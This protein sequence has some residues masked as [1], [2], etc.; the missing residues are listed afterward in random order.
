MIR[1]FVAAL[2][3]CAVG[4]IAIANA[5]EPWEL[6]PRLME[7]RFSG[8]AS[9]TIGSTAFSDAAI[10]IVALANTA[11]I[12]R[13]IISS[14]FASL[15]VEHQKASIEIEGVGKAAFTQ[16]T[17][18]WTREYLIGFARDFETYLNSGTDLVTVNVQSRLPSWNLYDELPTFPVDVFAVIENQFIDIQ[19]S[20]GPLT[21][22]R[23]SLQSGEFSAVVVPEPATGFASVVG[24][25]VICLRRTRRKMLV[26]SPNADR[27]I[28]VKHR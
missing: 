27:P 11:Q 3:Q 6:P 20:L 14:A 19:T 18:T 5:A 28:N 1:V 7:H 26:R 25:S 15:W 23:A 10:E 17:E 16:I 8:F 9:G 4:A 12:E 22:R 13:R 24:L 2:W 21:L